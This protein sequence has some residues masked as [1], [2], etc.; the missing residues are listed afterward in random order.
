[1]FSLKGT[2]NSQRR[3]LLLLLRIRYAHLGMVREAG[4]LARFMNTREKK[5]LESV[6]KILKENWG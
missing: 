4:T 1:M 2:T 6:I 5:I 3:C